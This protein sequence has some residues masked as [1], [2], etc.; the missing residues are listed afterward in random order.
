MN[1]ALLIISMLSFAFGALSSIGTYFGSTAY[2]L[3][4]LASCT[5]ICIP[6]S[7]IKKRIYRTI[8]SLLPFLTL[9][10]P[11]QVPT[12]IAC[13]LACAAFSVYMA[14]G[15]F[16]IPYY[17]CK[18]VFMIVM[19]V[20]LM[21]SLVTDLVIIITP[22]AKEYLNLQGICIFLLCTL[23]SGVLTLRSVRAGEASA[24]LRW[25]VFN[26]S[27]FA[28]TIAVLASAAIVLYLALS[29]L[30]SFI[31]PLEERD[32]PEYKSNPEQYVS[33]NYYTPLDGSYNGGPVF[34]TP[35]DDYDRL[36]TLVANEEEKNNTMLLI[37]CSV[38]TAAGI[39]ALI[40]LK[41]SKR[42]QDADDR[43]FDRQMQS[44]PDYSNRQKVR[45]YFRSYMNSRGIDF[46]KGST[47]E[48]VA[49]NDL[50]TEAALLREIYIKARYSTDSQISN[51]EV[52]QARICLEKCLEEDKK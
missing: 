46:S 16:C 23:F 11:S 21:I 33:N 22:Q 1:S 39:A 27:S 31:K 41:C 37:V 47:S 5:V 40:L 43:Q 13:T 17:K 4:T 36:E 3:I 35:V 14:I 25:K 44:R 6:A 51:S 29:F 19:A 32:L 15:N 42:P 38:I 26:F 52:D 48:D 34:G 7:L 50:R 8:V 2:F 24:G 18:R 49:R 9:L 12:I 30:F 28:V 20:L 10:F 45:L